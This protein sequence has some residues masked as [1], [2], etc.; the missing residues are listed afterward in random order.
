MQAKGFGVKK[1]ET[2]TMQIYP[3]YVK[4]EIMFI[5]GKPVKDVDVKNSVVIIDGKECNPSKRVV[6]TMPLREATRAGL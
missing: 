5:N 2:F 4:P 1:K 6:V 3:Q